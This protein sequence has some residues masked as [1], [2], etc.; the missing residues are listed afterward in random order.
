MRFTHYL[1]IAIVCLVSLAACDHNDFPSGPKQSIYSYDTITVPCM[2]DLPY[3]SVHTAVA[4]GKQL[5]NKATTDAEYYICGII[6]SFDKKYHEDGMNG[7]G[8]AV[9]YIRDSQTSSVE[10]EAFRIFGIDNQPFSG[11]NRM[12]KVAIGDTVIICGKITKYNNTIETPQTKNYN[13]YLYWTSNPLAYP[14]ED[15]SLFTEDFASLDYWSQ[16]AV[17]DPGMT[18]W[19]LKDKCVVAQA[20]PDG[21][22]VT[23][24][25]ELVS[26]PINLAQY[27][28]QTAKLAFQ[29]YFQQ[30][31]AATVRDMLTVRVT[32]DGKN[33][34]EMEIPNFNS[35]TLPKYVNDTLDITDYISDKTQIAFVYRSTDEVAPLWNIKQVSI[36]ENRSGKPI[37][38]K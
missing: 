29:T 35:G 14:M 26:Q 28:M 25:V 31:N 19:N 24:E 18:V 16:N 9:F 11:D 13:A 21:Q 22:P 5:E 3:I 33:W 23:S 2:E 27:N 1:F 15:V 6:C 10:F 36:F 30:G 38:T 32:E 20:K 8:N 7:Y 12:D 4:I 37:C 17:I 34:D